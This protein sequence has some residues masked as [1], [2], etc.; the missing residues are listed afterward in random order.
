MRK[1]SLR[2]IYKCPVLDPSGKEVGY[3]DDVLFHP[4][5]PIAVG[6]SVIPTYRIGGVFRLKDKYL[7]LEMTEV[8]GEGE[9]QT[10]V[11]KEAWG[12]RATKV[13]GYTWDETVVWYGQHIHTEGGQH[14][15]RI[16]DALFS[17]D[18]G[19][20][21]AIEV[22]EGTMTDLSLG[23]RTIPAEMILRF[24]LED[25]HAI[26]VDDDA[27]QCFY[28]GGLAVR[29]GKQAAQAAQAGKQA[30]KSGIVAAG[31]A[32]GRIEMALKGHVGSG[33]EPQSGNLEGD[34]TSQARKSGRWFGSMIKNVRDQ[35][36]EGL[37]D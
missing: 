27:E 16:S 28:A 1:V 14:L 17:L 5:Q 7:A 4:T 33:E 15:G 34:K 32:V 13:L 36:N 37:G 6:Y 10:L 12:R 22:T 35:Y 23:K 19:T 21:G 18:D 26:V 3:I 30:T 29:I 20:V 2:E 11:K 31:H 9:I 8:T 25:L 24:Q